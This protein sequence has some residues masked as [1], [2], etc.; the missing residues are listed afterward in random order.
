MRLY[1]QLIAVLVL[2]VAIQ[3]LIA[4]ERKDRDPDRNPRAPVV[5][6][7]AQ[8]GRPFT[9]DLGR[10]ESLDFVWVAPMKMLVG[11]YEVSNGQFRRYDT[12]HDST[13]VIERD[14]DEDVQPVVNVSWEEANNYCGWLNRRYGS[15]IPTDVVFRLPTER[16]WTTLARCGD[17]RTYPWGNQWPPPDTCN[18][19]GVEGSGLLY[20]LCQKEQFIRGHNDGYIVSCPITNS[21]VN[22]W[23]L[24]GVSGNV[25]E[26]CGDWFDTKKETRVIRGGAWNNER[27]SA[28]RIAHRAAA[29]PEWDNASIGFRVVIG[30]PIP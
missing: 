14:F 15:Q 11:K 20:S 9:I 25:W 3:G 21:G 1:H 8:P 6:E 7:P 16:E 13:N 26:W 10:D 4:E 19:R 5:Q 12:S 23:G 22:A 29:A 30:P 17:Q 28:L 27:E 2:G 24:Y 18:Y